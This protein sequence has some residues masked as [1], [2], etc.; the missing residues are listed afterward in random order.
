VALHRPGRAQAP[1]HLGAPTRRRHSAIIAEGG[2]LYPSLSEQ[3]EGV[4]ALD[5]ATGTTIWEHIYDAPT[6]GVD[7]SEGAGPHSTPLIVG[8]TLYAASSFKQL[9]AIDKAGRIATSR[10]RRFSSPTRS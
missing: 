8:N 7:F 6:S 3:K 2:R 1:A 10:V 9:I 5:A 4:V